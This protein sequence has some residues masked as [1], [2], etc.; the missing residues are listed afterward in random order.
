MGKI[1]RIG[2]LIAEIHKIDTD[3]TI[4]EKDEF[5]VELIKEFVTENDVASDN[6]LNVFMEALKKDNN[7][8]RA[9]VI[10][11]LIDDGVISWGDLLKIGIRQAFI[12][13]LEMNGTRQYSDPNG[14]LYKIKNLSTEVYFWGIPASGKTCAIGA[15]LS[16]AAKS[17]LPQINVFNNGG[18]CQGKK[19]M[20][21]LT[22]MFPYDISDEVRD[23]VSDVMPLPNGTHVEN[24]YE[25]FFELI[26]NR[27]KVLPI[28]FIDMAGPGF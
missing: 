11:G 26:D 24:T 12:D 10:N 8:V 14:P 17:D 22:R 2:E 3:N 16:M 5:I 21:E 6:R 9:M 20:N 18:D 28:T 1:R 27:N 23:D 7:L 13:A 4:T 19:Y 15:M 25:M